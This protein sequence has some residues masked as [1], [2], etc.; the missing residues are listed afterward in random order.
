MGVKKTGANTIIEKD[1]GHFEK[2]MLS[3]QLNSSV[4]LHLNFKD[5]WGW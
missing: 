1:T 3:Q 5:P 2:K 4:K